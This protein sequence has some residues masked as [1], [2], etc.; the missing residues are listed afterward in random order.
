M[1]RMG[2][3]V[4]VN[5]HFDE[6]EDRSE[7]RELPEIE[8]RECGHSGTLGHGYWLKIASRNATVDFCFG[9]D[10]MAMSRFADALREKVESFVE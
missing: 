5:V 3:R 4:N 8:A 1:W 10:K 7:I 9:N 2:D 6:T